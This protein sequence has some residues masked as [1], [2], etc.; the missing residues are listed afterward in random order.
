[1]PLPMLAALVVASA[2][3]PQESVVPAASLPVE[4]PSGS[5]AMDLVP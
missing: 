5:A 1:M 3:L 4:F 2:L